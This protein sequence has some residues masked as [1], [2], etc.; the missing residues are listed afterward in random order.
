MN[1]PM[2]TFENMTNN[3]KRM[4]DFCNKLNTYAHDNIGDILSTID[5]NK[6]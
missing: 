1:Y 2:Q 6:Q 5:L 3:I 4:R